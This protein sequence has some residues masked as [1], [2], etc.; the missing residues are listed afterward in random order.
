[1][2]EE[3]F[4]KKYCYDSNISREFFDKHLVALPC[5]CGWE[6]CKGWAAVS[7]DP[8]SIRRH[9]ELYGGEL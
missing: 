5:S 6:R 3:E 9:K 4:I 7:I 2:N 1:M 8:D